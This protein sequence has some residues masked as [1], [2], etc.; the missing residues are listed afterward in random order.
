MK[1]KTIIHKALGSVLLFLVSLSTFNQNF[2]KTPLRETLSLVNS[3]TYIAVEGYY[4][5][6]SSFMVTHSSDAIVE[7]GIRY[8]VYEYKYQLDLYNN[9]RS[10]MTEIPV[11]SKRNM[12]GEEHSRI[13]LLNKKLTNRTQL[14]VDELATYGMPIVGDT[15]KYVQTSEGREYITR[16]A[17]LRDYLFYKGSMPQINESGYTLD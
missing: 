14:I 3:N 8:P 4:V 17:D 11:I 7:I 6:N 16:L 13:L 15:V 10:N 2:Y 12:Q 5:D 1:K 9:K